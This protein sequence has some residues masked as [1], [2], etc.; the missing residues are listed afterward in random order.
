MWHVIWQTVFYFE[1]VHS[2]SHTGH[3][4]PRS[5][6]YHRFDQVSCLRKVMYPMIQIYIFGPIDQNISSLWALLPIVLGFRFLSL[7]LRPLENLQL[8]IGIK[9]VNYECLIGLILKYSFIQIYRYPCW[10]SFE[11][12]WYNK[13]SRA[14]VTSNHRKLLMSSQTFK[15]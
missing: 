7:Y 9:V 14:R 10:W 1:I 13:D 4:F 11:M 12:S 2:F 8:H 3:L 6:M 15:P 5:Y